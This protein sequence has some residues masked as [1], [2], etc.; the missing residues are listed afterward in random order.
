MIGTLINAVDGPFNTSGL[1][2]SIVAD[3]ADLSIWEQAVERINTIESNDIMKIAGKYLQPQ[4]FW[5]VSSGRR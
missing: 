5:I 2:K 4:D 1:I 3:Q